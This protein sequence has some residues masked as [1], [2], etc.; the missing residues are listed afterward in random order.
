MGG[1]AVS[2][3]DPSV[4]DRIWPAL[5]VVLTPL[6]LLVLLVVA[7]D[8]AVVWSGTQIFPSPWSVLVG[9]VELAHEGLLLRY[10]ISSLYRVT[11]GFFLAVAIGVPFGLALGW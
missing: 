7:W 10:T 3:D 11:W 5:R 6:A 2:R 8:R 9:I 4:P 1:A